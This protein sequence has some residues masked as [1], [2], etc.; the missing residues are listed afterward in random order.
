[1]LLGL[2]LGSTTVKYVLLD[3]E[4][5]LLARDYRRHKSDLIQTVRTLLSELNGR[6]P[7]RPVRPVLSGSGA[8]A[9]SE[10]LRVAFLQEVAAGATFLAE[11]LPD[12]DV[13]IELGGEDAKLLYLTNGLELRM[14]EACA[15]GTGAFIDQMAALLSTD[16]AGLDELAL[17]ASASHPIASRCGVFA[18]TDLVALLNAGVPRSAAARSVFDAVAEQTISGLACGRP[19]RGK[20]VF[21][22]GPLSFLKGLRESFM[23]KLEGPG[24][25]FTALD[26]AHFAVAYGA[27]LTA[28]ESAELPSLGVLIDRFASARVDGEAGRLPALFASDEELERFRARHEKEKVERGNLADARG[29]LYLGIDLGST[30]VKGVLIDGEGR[31]LSAWY[32]RNE[33]NPLERLFPRVKTLAASIPEGARIRSICTT[34]YGAELAKA[35]LGADWAEV[36]TLAHQRAAA[37]FAP[38]VSYVIDIGGQDMKCLAVKDGLISG[39]SLNEACSSGCGSFLQT[40]SDQLELTLPEFVA[41]ALRSRAPVDLGTRCTV[42]MNSKVRQAQRDGATT[43]DIAAGLC[44]SIVR[45]ALYKVLRIRNPEELGKHVV[46]QGGTFL[47]DGVLRAFETH[48][49]REVIRP[50]IAGHM[51]AYGAAL[52]AKE[53]T[54]AETPVP[55]L[56]EKTFDLTDVK[57][58][59]FLCRGCSNHCHLT[60]HRFASGEKFVSGNRCEFALKSLGR[61]AKD[62]VSFHDEKTA[63]LFDRPSSE[64]SPR[65]TIG[66]P[67]VLN[68]YEHYPFWHAFFTKL[69]FKV[70]LSPA[71]NRDISAKGT[72]TI[73]SQTLCWP[74][75]LAHGH[76]T[77]LAE[78]GVERIWL[79]SVAREGTPFP[80]GD[81]RYAC[82][83][84]GGYP[85]VLRLNLLSTFP[86]VSLMAPF[87]DLEREDSV[88]SG[89]C[90]SFPELDRN[91]VREAFRAGREAL[92]HYRGQLRALGEERAALARAK[93]VPLIVLAGHPYHLDPLVNHGI[94]TLIASMG[95]EVVTEDAVAHLV[96][97]PQPLS[98]VNQWTFHS[99]LYRA[100]EYALEHPDVEVVQLVSFGCGLDAVTSEQMKRLLEPEG[101][102]YTLLKIDEGDAFGAARI[103]LRSLMAALDDRRRTEKH[104]VIP[105]ASIP[106]GHA[107]ADDEKTEQPKLEKGSTLYIPQMAPIHFPVLASALGSLGYDVKLLS[108]VRPNALELGLR[109]VNNDACYPAIV[110]IGQFLDALASGEID[111]EKPV[112]VLAQTCGPC[113]ATN[114]PNLLRWA[115]HDYGRPEIPVYSISAGSIDPVHALPIGVKGLHRLTHAVLYGDMLQRLTYSVR[116]REVTKGD[117]E[118]L[119]RKWTDIVS[120]RVKNGSYFGYT[121]TL[122]RMA[123]DYLRVPVRAERI[124]RAGVVGEI[125][126]KYHPD[127]NQRIVDEMIDQGVEPVV[128]DLS[129]FF[130]YCLYDDVYRAEQYGDSRGKAWASKLLIGWIESLR[131]RSAS[132]LEGTPFPK[133]RSLASGLAHIRGVVSAGQQAGEGWL[134]TAEMMES[135]ENG[136]PNVVCLQP[137]G[138]LP[139]HITGKGVMRT[140]RERF[141]EANLCAIDFEAGT[142]RANVSNRLKLFLRQ[143]KEHFEK[144]NGKP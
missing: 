35:A 60:L 71:S 29:D 74:A 18:K 98:V 23:R 73:P 139:N 43:D 57:R 105:I 33:G 86:K 56:D 10:A 92:S 136:I 140:L 82:P 17:S 20:I 16:A 28:D 111:A 113:R 130:L 143:A 125:L 110:V 107:A 53:R 66:I 13:A 39:V 30:T 108:D 88:L 4:R 51:G 15:G 133:P 7:N 55:E 141:P 129:S 48:V 93:G 97:N 123:A 78:K 87:I 40:F 79:P 19:I 127:A 54:S 1:M 76:V 27:A 84:V 5:K 50:D 11:R 115:L 14:N 77:W 75:K 9:L 144:E 45:N 32:E 52:I 22:G 120:L 132:V 90:E 38:D 81:A 122:R 138:C 99:R 65:G 142:S 70:L 109:Y 126:L 137:F 63:L 135:L 134:L 116:A 96:L 95:A 67:R 112:L 42:F 62:E 114:Y 117:A 106:H 68:V 59:E 89:V 49:G 24:T 101:K 8:L 121:D 83:V 80:E 100:A 102:L 31:F 124:P 72:E 12:A 103:R 64:D 36:E 21:L 37:H 128:G 44:H 131:K 69:G 91:E 104:R 118:E 34:G 25:S 94:P 85:E 46:V 3:D 26:D 58:R 47:N 119:R 6:F 2:D 61:A 41:A